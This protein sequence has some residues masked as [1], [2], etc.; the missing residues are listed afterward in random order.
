MFRGVFKTMLA[1]G[2]FICL[3]AFC[4]RSCTADELMKLRQEKERSQS[5]ISFL[6][7]ENQQLRARLIESRTEAIKCRLD[8]EKCREFPARIIFRETPK[9]F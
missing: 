8:L 2:A 9:N 3:V 1:L 6:K 4:F 7:E 5:K